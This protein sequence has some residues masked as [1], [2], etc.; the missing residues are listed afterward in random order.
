MSKKGW[1][2]LLS[3][4]VNK[5]IG[6]KSIQYRKGEAWLFLKLDLKLLD[7]NSLRTQVKKPL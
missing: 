2:P 6:K 4:P 1:E 3:P 7:P 5:N